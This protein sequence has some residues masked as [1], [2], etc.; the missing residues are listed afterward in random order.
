MP[1]TKHVFP[2]SLMFSF[3]FGTVRSVR[4]Y[5]HNIGV[6]LRMFPSPTALPGH[7]PKCDVIMRK[8]ELTQV[9]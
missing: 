4:P 8:G 2:I 6:E 7:L 9:R 1:V 3:N 5:I